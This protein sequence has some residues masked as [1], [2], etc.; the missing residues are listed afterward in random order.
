[1]ANTFLWSLYVSFLPTGKLEKDPGVQEL[2]LNGSGEKE[3]RKKRQAI[4]LLLIYHQV[5]QNNNTKCSKQKQGLVT[6]T[7]PTAGKSD[8]LSLAP[9]QF[10]D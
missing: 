7:I 1:M 10:K 6:W 5:S 3:N 8:A 2:K 4:A 9:T